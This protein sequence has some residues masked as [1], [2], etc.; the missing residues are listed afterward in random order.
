MKDLPPCHTISELETL[1]N[2]TPAA[3]NLVLEVNFLKTLSLARKG[4]L[5]LVNPI[6]GNTLASSRSSF[7]RSMHKAKN[8]LEIDNQSSLAN[9]LIRYQLHCAFLKLFSSKAKYK[10]G[11]ACRFAAARKNLTRVRDWS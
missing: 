6:E 2:F 9:N 7:K 1:C 3:A 11:D 10:R 8:S 5:G 4:P